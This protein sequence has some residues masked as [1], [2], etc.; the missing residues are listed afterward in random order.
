MVETVFENRF[1]HLEEMRRM[2]LHSELSVIQL[3]LLVVNL[4]GAE[5]LS[6]DLRA[7]AALRF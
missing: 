2:G 6:T 3:V 1:Q 4:C 5:V 7:S